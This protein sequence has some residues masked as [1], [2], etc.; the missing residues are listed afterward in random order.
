LYKEFLHELRNKNLLLK[1]D[2]NVIW[3]AIFPE[4]ATG[5]LEKSL[6]DDNLFIIGDAAG[7]VA[8][9][10][11][12]GIHAAIVS[13]Q[14]AGETSLNALERNN[15]TINTLKEFKQHSNIKRII[16][17]FKFQ[18]KFVNFFYENEGENLNKT[19]KMVEESEEFKQIVIDTFIFGQTPPKDFI[20][21]IKGS[22]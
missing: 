3:S 13:G 20:S 19:F 10:S 9:I 14:V 16:R 8:P 18:R 21:K 15:F 17:L 7:F 2:Y 6:C 22:N 4:P 12:E 11:G 1:K 5:V